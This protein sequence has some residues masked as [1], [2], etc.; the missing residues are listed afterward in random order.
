MSYVELEEDLARHSA[1][2]L[3]DVLASLPEKHAARTVQ[4]DEGATYAPKLQK[5]FSSI[6][7]NKWSAATIEARWRA[8]GYAVSAL[9]V[10]QC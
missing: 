5:R 3:V 1:E 10:A 8:F 7:W 2:L 6:R 4:H 9:G